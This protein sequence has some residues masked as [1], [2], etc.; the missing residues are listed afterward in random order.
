MCVSDVR[1]SAAK[2]R[3]GFQITS[4]TSEFKESPSDQSAGGVAPP[5]LA[6][7]ALQGSSSQ[8][9]TPSLKRKYVSH[10][11]PAQDAACSRFRV[12]RLT[13]AGSRGGGRGKPYRRGRW[14]CTEFVE[15]QE[16]VG[17]RRVLDSMR[18][19]HSLESL[20]MIGWEA[21]RGG[22]HSQ[23]PAHLRLQHGAG[24]GPRSGPP[25]PTHGQAASLR[26]LDCRQPG[27]DDQLDSRPPSPPG[28]PAVPP[29]P[30]QLGRDRAG[31][32]RTDV[33]GV[34]NRRQRQRCPVCLSVSVPAQFSPRWIQHPDS[35]DPSSL[36]PGSEHLQ[37]AAGRQVTSP[38]LPWFTA[39]GHVLLTSWRTVVWPQ[40]LDCPPLITNTGE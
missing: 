6:T 10:E 24:V 19:A 1:M 17:F 8:P 28:R 5:D 14:T 23:G 29:T 38:Y 18:H 31:Q 4:V 26:L 15:W 16:G 34:I 21:G 9:S 25:S 3:S 22:V 39:V 20:E 36:Q 12:V 7:S 11:A 32:V 40:L 30:T 27:G 13:A 33:L 35:P 37:P 2:K